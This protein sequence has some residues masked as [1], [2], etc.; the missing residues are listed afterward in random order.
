[1]IVDWRSSHLADYGWT[2]TPLPVANDTCY[3]HPA[4]SA[5]TGGGDHV[6][7][8]R[9]DR[10]LHTPIDVTMLDKETN[11]SVASMAV[12]PSIERCWQL[13]WTPPA[14]QQPCDPLLPQSSFARSL[15]AALSTVPLITTSTAA[16]RSDPKASSLTDSAASSHDGGALVCPYIGG[17]YHLWLRYPS[18]AWTHPQMHFATP[19]Y[20]PRVDTNGSIRLNSSWY[21]YACC[22]PACCYQHILVF[23][24][25]PIMVFALYI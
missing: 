2:R 1:M 23:D 19:I 4:F 5:P 22:L 15:Y 21:V 6:T 12:P 25:G 3:D 17:R 10:L 13:T 20:S 9:T 18:D 14:G 11:D 24:A 8:T 7:R 16:T